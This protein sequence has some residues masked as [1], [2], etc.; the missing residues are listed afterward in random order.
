MHPRTVGRPHEECYMGRSDEKRN[1]AAGGFAGIWGQWVSR[2]RN[3][4]NERSATD[5]K[6]PVNISCKLNRYP[7]KKF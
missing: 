1:G 6:Q 5:E 3:F 4:L 2:S 7:N